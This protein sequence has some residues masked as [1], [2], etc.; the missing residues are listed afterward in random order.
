MTHRM[1]L[2]FA[3]AASTAAAQAPAPS[4][5]VLREFR[6]SGDYV[7]TVGGKEVPAEIYQSERAAA[8]L[9]VSSAFPSPVLLEPRTG[10]AETVS[11][12]KM[13]KQPDGSIDLLAD[14]VLAPQGQIQFAED[15]V[16]FSAEGRSGALKPKPPLLGLRRAA[17]VTQ[18]NPEYALGARTYKTNPHAIANLRK[19]GRPVQVRIY[20]GSWCPHCRQMVPHALRIEQELKGS[21]SGVRF[22]YWGLPQAFGNDPEAKK[23]GVKA[24]PT[25]V[26]YL[27]GK[28]AGRITGNA[29]ESPE[30]ALNEILSAHPAAASKSGSGPA[31]RASGSGPR[32]GRPRPA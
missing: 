31:G 22:E 12:M 17:E 18:H 1:V 30:T 8:I 15:A 21:Q 26:V 4:D 9:V 6:P 28:E 7:L 16:S 3:L 5:N 2:A 32:P 10:M 29:W 24:V 23:M 11:V 19:E 14:A 20:Y 25:G 27:N 13:A